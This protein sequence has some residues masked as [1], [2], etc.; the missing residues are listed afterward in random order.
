[1]NFGLR[2]DQIGLNLASSVSY[3]EVEGFVLD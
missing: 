2:W 1:M 3:L